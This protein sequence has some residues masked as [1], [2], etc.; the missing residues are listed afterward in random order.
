MKK[1]T[2][3]TLTILSFN[4]SIAQYA[5]EF[6]PSS[7]LQQVQISG[8]TCPNE[9]TIEAWINFKGIYDPGQYPTIFE[10]QEDA[11]FF[12]ITDTNFLTLYGAVTSNTTIPLNQWTHVAVTYSTANSEANI[13]ING[14]LD[15]SETGISINISGIGAGIGYNTVDE[16]FNGSIDDVR[17]WNTV[18][19]DLEISSNMNTC[20][21]GSETNLYAFYN[22][23]EGSGTTVNDL[24]SNSFDGTLVNMDPLTDWI[25]YDSC[26]TLSIDNPN[27]NLQIS[28][29]PNPA[30]DIISVQ[31]LK[32]KTDYV[33]YNA[34]GTKVLE[35]NININDNIDV[36]KLASG[37]YLLKF[38]NRGIL[39]FVKK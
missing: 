37:I 11:P 6:D 30:T 16:V 7:G 8:I 2:L 24:T 35:G 10:F 32:N 39:K 36:Q 5:L 19:T 22:F 25:A 21:T 3:L 9:F 34:I 1:I 15:N 17:I 28:L 4:F 12:G 33:V 31:G 23:D 38:N 14:V 26:N 20:L 13:Y 18:R 27:N 29:Y